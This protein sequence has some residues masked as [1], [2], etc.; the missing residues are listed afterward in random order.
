MQTSQP[1]FQEP[2]SV[3]SIT[4]VSHIKVSKKEKDYTRCD[5]W[6]GLPQVPLAA[7]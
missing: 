4:L 1:A 5:R 6:A 3:I 7:T 2:E